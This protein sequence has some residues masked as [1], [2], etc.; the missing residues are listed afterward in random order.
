M[1]SKTWKCDLKLGVKALEYFSN[2]NFYKIAWVAWFQISNLESKICNCD[3]TF[4]VKAFKYSY[5]L[6]FYKHIHTCTTP[7]GCG[8]WNKTP[9]FYTLQNH[10]H[11]LWNKRPHA[12]VVYL[13]LMYVLILPGSHVKSM[14]GART[15]LSC[16]L[17]V[18]NTFVMSINNGQ[19]WLHSGTDLHRTGSHL[20]EWWVIIPDST[21]F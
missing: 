16:E 14:H 9:P 4:R 2:L 11:G 21:H 5:H 8:V 20:T 10:R 17:T 13:G 7:N 15:L 6:N 1:E 19:H 3:L 18:R 12:N